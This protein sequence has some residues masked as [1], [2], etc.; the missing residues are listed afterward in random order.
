M[1]SAL[2]KTVIETLG[3][4]QFSGDLVLAYLW[5]S[6]GGVLG[7]KEIPSHAVNTT[8]QMLRQDIE[9]VLSRDAYRSSQ[10]LQSLRFMAS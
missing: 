6:A 5:N 2:A 4:E 3:R 1:Q 8:E 10:E 7:L 9:A